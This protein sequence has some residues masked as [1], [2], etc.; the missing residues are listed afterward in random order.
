MFRWLSGCVASGVL[1]AAQPAS[2]EWVEATSDHFVVYGDLRP[3]EAAIFAEQLERIDKLLR[4]VTNTPDTAAERANKVTV[5]FVPDMA[6]V[7]RLYGAGG[8]DVGGFYRPDAQGSLAVTPKR[9]AGIG[10]YMRPQQILFHEYAH[11]ILISGAKAAYPRWINEGLA[12]FFGTIDPRP[13]GSLILGG[14]PLIRGFALAEQNQMSAQELLTA[15][16]RRL[17]NTDVGHLYARGWAMVHM[18]MLNKERA[19]QLDTYLRLIAE[20]MPS[21][22]AGTKAFGSLGKL[23]TDLRVHL[24]SR[25]FPSIVVPAAKVSGGKAIVRTLTGCEAKIMPVRVRSAVGVTDKTAPGVAAE[26]RRAAAGCENDVFVQRTLAETEYDAKNNGASAAAAD[27]AFAK[28]SNNIMAM[29]YR[30]RVHARAGD[31]ANARKW[32]IRANK[33]NP[34]YALPLVLYHDSFTAA[35]QTPSAAA[36]NGL[37]R[38]LVLVPQDSGVRTRVVRSAVVGG[39]METARAALGALA[40]APHSKADSPAAKILKMIDERKDKAVIL[41]EMDKA[42]WNE[43]SKF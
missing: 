21:L 32:F 5:Y 12:E 39:D 16:Q 23:D 22:D 40:L 13:D 27:R 34:D 14:L 15:D 6:T 42:K 3:S 24:R 9:L 1:C 25:K 41:A 30:G 10:Q 18:L 28:D 38:A 7:Q 29:V 11:A 4:T 33:T 20:G 37:L 26:A 35:G 31:W 2:A 36:Q 8:G 17:S 43:I 19:G